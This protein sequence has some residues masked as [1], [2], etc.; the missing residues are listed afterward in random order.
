MIYWQSF[1]DNLL[2]D[3]LLITVS[4]NN[5]PFCHIQSS[6]GY[7]QRLRLMFDIQ[8][9]IWATPTYSYYG[10]WV[11][12][13][14]VTSSKKTQLFDFIKS[15]EIE[16]IYSF[17]S[18]NSLKLWRDFFLKRLSQSPTSFIYNGLWQI[19][20]LP[21]KSKS[22]GKWFFG[23]S[24]KKYSKSVNSY[25]TFDPQQIF[26]ENPSYIAWEGDSNNLIPLKAV[27][28][29]DSRLKWWHKKILED[30]LPPILVWYIS[31]LCAYVIID[32]HYRLYAAIKNNYQPNFIVIK[33]LTPFYFP[34]DDKKLSLL[35]LNNI[36]K[37]LLNNPNPNI[38]NIN[39]SL[40]SAFDNRPQ[41]RSITRAT[42]ANNLN[43][44]WQTQVEQ[45]LT[46]L[47]KENYIEFFLK[48]RD[49]D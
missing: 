22:L 19:N 33:S 26:K 25:I 46:K 6:S 48:K 42:V 47:N 17:K 4:G 2:D 14:S 3:T 39:D 16:N 13:N 43:S 20:T 36:N 34:Q 44:I 28:P 9:L 29:E 5:N 31:G 35:I 21:V 37:H 40:I 1:D 24:Y 18:K 41:M 32:G 45:E 8:P 15:S 12:T 11:L 30:R 23:D 10:I 27:N 49:I 7:L 38:T